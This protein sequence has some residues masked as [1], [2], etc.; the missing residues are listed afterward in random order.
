MRP[1]AI[2]I[3]FLVPDA[4]AAGV[5]LWLDGDALRIRGPH[6]AADLARQLRE[7]EQEVR[8]YL[9]SACAS[10]CGPLWWKWPDDDRRCVSCRLAAGEPAIPP[11]VPTCTMCGS[12]L[13][14]DESIN[15]GTCLVCDLEATG[16]RRVPVSEDLKHTGELRLT[17]EAA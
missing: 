17:D 12:A 8:D 14:A 10:C 3:R 9:P 1:P 7:R 2:L 4:V 5:H 15:R 6:T 16:R 11:G 13:L